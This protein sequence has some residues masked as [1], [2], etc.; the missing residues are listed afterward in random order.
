MSNISAIQL[1]YMILFLLSFSSIPTE[2]KYLILGSPL[3]IAIGLLLLTFYNS[4][5][6]SVK[7]KLNLYLICFF[8]VVMFL[9]LFINYYISLFTLP[10]IVINLFISVRTNIK[11]EL[12]TISIYN[13][14]LTFFGFL[15]LSIGFSMPH[16]YVNE[17]IYSLI[18]FGMLFFCT[19]QIL[20]IFGILKKAC[21]KRLIGSLF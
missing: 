9:S 5:V 10:I 6:L 20:N 18:I 19:I 3:L 14:A 21:E 4:R 15:F 7:N 1:L 17:T 11:K 8:T 13:E 16:K 2:S 12:E